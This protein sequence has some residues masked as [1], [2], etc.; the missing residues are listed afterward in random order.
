MDFTI[1]VYFAE[2]R[3]FSILFVSLFC[4]KTERGQKEKEMI[5]KD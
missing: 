3:S 5:W 4:K 1:K 2:K